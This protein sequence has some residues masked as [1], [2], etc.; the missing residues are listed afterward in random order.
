M[1]PQ[2]RFVRKLKALGKPARE[3]WKGIFGFAVVCFL[4]LFLKQKIWKHKIEKGL[5]FLLGTSDVDRYELITKMGEDF[6]RAN[7][8]LLNDFESLFQGR[9]DPWVVKEPDN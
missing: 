1:D 2:Q 8:F 9:S 7:L 5:D 4:F 3:D 6:L